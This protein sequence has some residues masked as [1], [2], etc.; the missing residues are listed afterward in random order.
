MYADIL[1]T[2]SKDHVKML[3]LLKEVGELCSIADFA[4]ETLS[5]EIKNLELKKIV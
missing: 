2:S 3:R 1:T 5:A 4:Q